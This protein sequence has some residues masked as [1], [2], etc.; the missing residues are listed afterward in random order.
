M[1]E[2]DL[3][4]EIEQLE[5][6]ASFQSLNVNSIAEK[7]IKNGNSMEEVEAVFDQYDF[8]IVKGGNS[9]SDHKLNKI[10][11]IYDFIKSPALPAEYRLVIDVFFSQNRV[12]NIKAVYLKHMF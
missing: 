6:P 8:Q 5:K 4:S 3:I 1:A 2:N 7:Y 10:T 9:L 12:T 11:G